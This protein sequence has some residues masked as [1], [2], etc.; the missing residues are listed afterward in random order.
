MI[1]ELRKGNI[2]GQKIEKYQSWIL[3]PKYLFFKSCWSNP[4]L[5]LAML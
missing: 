3:N 4:E 2:L 1:N 5:A